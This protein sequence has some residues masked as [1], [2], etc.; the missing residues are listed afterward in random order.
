MRQIKSLYAGHPKNPPAFC[1]YHNCFLT[2]AE[3]KRHEC[4]KKQCP[5]MIRF[6]QHDFWRQREEK[7][8]QKKASRAAFAAKCAMFCQS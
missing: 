7:K 1:K 2:P 3:M 5:N 6:E 4:L 8:Q